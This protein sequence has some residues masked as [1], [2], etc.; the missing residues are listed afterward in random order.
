M[1]QLIIVFLFDNVDLFIYNLVD[2][3]CIME[4][5]IVVYCNNV[6]V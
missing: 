6:L 4:L 1:S 5:N 3:L 2:E